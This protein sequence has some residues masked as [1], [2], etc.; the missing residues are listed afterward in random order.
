MHRPANAALLLLSLSPLSPMTSS[1]SIASLTLSKSGEKVEDTPVIQLTLPGAAA[2]NEK[3]C[4]FDDVTASGAILRLY[5]VEES[6]SSYNVCNNSTSHRNRTATLQFIIL[7]TSCS[8][9]P[10]QFCE[11]MKIS[12]EYISRVS[13]GRVCRENFHCLCY[14]GYLKLGNFF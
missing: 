1:R 5:T 12:L 6:S 7:I 14:E 9:V 10:A 3:S 13:H 4:P 8:C 11:T 2:V